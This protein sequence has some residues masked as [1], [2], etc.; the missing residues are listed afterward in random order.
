NGSYE[1][2][3]RHSSSLPE[4]P[5]DDLR[6]VFRTPQLPFP[7]RR[8]PNRS[9][10]ATDIRESC[11]GNCVSIESGNFQ[12]G[13]SFL[14]QDTNAR[15]L[16]WIRDFRGSFLCSHAVVLP[17]QQSVR[18]HGSSWPASVVRQLRWDPARSHS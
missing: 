10:R 1:E 2:A 9:H 8:F 3:S 4:D 18:V 15:G 11:L 13:L 14:P 12:L 5:W 7:D 16:R 6:T 17:T